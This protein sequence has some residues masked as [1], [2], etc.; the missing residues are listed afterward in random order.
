ML[1]TNLW[2]FRHPP[3]EI[4]IKLEEL[5]KIA[6]VLE[7]TY[8]DYA[9]IKKYECLKSKNSDVETIKG[10]I[11][12]G[13]ERLEIHK[14]WDF[15]ENLIKSSHIKPETER[16]LKDVIYDAKK[17]GIVFEIYQNKCERGLIR[18]EEDDL[19]RI[20][21]EK[22]TENKKLIDELRHY[23]IYVGLQVMWKELVDTEADKLKKFEGEYKNN[24][25]KYKEALINQNNRLNSLKYCANYYITNE[26][27]EELYENVNKF[28][29]DSFPEAELNKEVSNILKPAFEDIKG[30][31]DKD[32]ASLLNE[33][34]IQIFCERLNKT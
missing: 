18:G 10:H 32:T 33:K 6:Y 14:Q 34:I 29:L 8:K 26:M 27:L 22:L 13:N 17:R 24:F 5:K 19:K 12:E 11:N 30:K 2:W 16:D 31:I 20:I 28:I 7:D 21:S 25:E 9:L 23:K 3:E 15:Y 4:E 1:F